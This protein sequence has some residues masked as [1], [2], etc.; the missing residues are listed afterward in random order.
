MSHRRLFATATAVLTAGACLVA[1]PAEAHR[2]PSAARDAVEVYSQHLPP[3]AT[4]DGVRIDG[5]GWGSSW[6]AKPSSDVLFYGLTDRG[7]NVDGPDGSK[8]EPLPGFTPSIGEFALV[9]GRAIL[10]RTIPLRAS[11]GTPYNG[12]VNSQASTGETIT[13]LDGNVLPAS[14]YGYDPEGLVALRDGSFWVSDEYGP[15]ITHFDRWGRQIE[16]LSPYDGTLPAELKNREPNRGMEGLTITPDG[17]TL[18]GIMQSGLNTSDGPKAKKASALRIVTIDLRTRATKEFV[19]LLH[20]GSEDVTTAASEI[21]AIS[22]TTFLVDE[23]DGNVEPGANKKLF[24]I[25]LTGATD[26]GPR[27]TVAGSTYD[28]GKGGLLV[29][30]QTVE[31]I[32]GKKSTVN[33]S[34]ALQQNGITPVSSSLF[35]DVA[36]L[37]TDIDPTGKFYGH[38]KLEGV[39][40]LHGGREVVISNDSDF[41]IDG[42]TNA[43]APFQLHAKTLPDGT[44]D[45]LQLLKVDLSKVPAAYRG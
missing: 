26:I 15:F 18:V 30:G 27:S 8:I 1:V 31:A 13:D 23:R 37:V 24:K 33:A 16:R 39:A 20:H 12:Q 3:L 44:Q 25:D 7:P 41:G 2:A 4:I 6:V 34:T 5:S 22:N 28:A 40:V 35:L 42:V 43:A 10:L 32:A 9:H 14:P 45:T 19:Y 21:S 29:N 36:G 11:N 17:R 38:D